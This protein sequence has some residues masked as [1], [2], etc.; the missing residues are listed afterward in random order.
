MFLSH[1][2]VLGYLAS[3]RVQSAIA[4]SSVSM[5]AHGQQAYS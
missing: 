1:V 2:L 3:T 4:D 5:L